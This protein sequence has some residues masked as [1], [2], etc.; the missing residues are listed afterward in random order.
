M[1][2]KPILSGR[3]GKWA[4]ALVEYDLCC[5]PIGS[6]KGQI[7]V[8]FIVQHR[9]DRQLDLNVDYVT[10]TP[11]KLHFDGSA[12]RSGCGVGIIIMSP[13][14][15]IFEALNRLDH[16]STNNQIEYE[17][18]LFGL[19]ILQDMG[20]K[21]LEAY[22]D[23]LL[24]VQ[25]VSK[26][27][28]CL[29]GSL[30]T[31]LDK[32]LDIISCMHDFV[33]YHVPR[34]KNLKTNALA[35]QASGY[36]VQKRNFQEQKP[37]FSEAEGYVLEEPVQPTP[38]A[39]QTGYPGQTAPTGQLDRP[40]GGNPTSAT[41]SS[42][43]VECEVGDW[44]TPLIKYLQDPKSISDR[45]VRRWALKFILDDDEL[46]RRTTDDL[47]LKC[48]GPDQARLAMAEVHDGICGT[49]QSAPKMKWLLRRAC[50]YCPTMIADCFR[51]YKGCE[52]CQK[53]G[54]VQL[55]PAALLHPIIK[56]WPFRGWGLDFIGKIHPPSTK[57]H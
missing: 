13:S 43:I 29:N 56:P 30:N 34:E 6:I 48:L 52:E 8:D 25:Q 18:L 4:Y 28:Q 27:C 10:F 21:H 11:W 38:P 31:Y 44:R 20:V 46:Y 1:L 36:N 5:E 53:H 42:K 14:G 17:A 15:A 22:G 45:K 57:G 23:S 47:L 54:D 40:S 9:I 16:K 19:Q 41:V 35:R 3:V 2:Q 26:V 39:G 51:Y 7:V 37:M 50:F 32:C 55:V 49:H 12:C 33:I 24:V